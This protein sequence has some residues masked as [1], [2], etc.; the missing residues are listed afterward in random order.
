MPNVP[1][2]RVTLL[3]PSGLERGIWDEGDGVTVLERERHFMSL[4]KLKRD[5]HRGGVGASSVCVSACSFG[6]TLSGSASA[7]RLG[8]RVPAVM[9]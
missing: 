1:W 8:K 2:D 9:L 5:G 4:E 3:R 6:V 7:E